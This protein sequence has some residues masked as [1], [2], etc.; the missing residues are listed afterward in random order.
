MSS[1]NVSAVTPS[2]VAISHKVRFLGPGGE[3]LWLLA[4]SVAGT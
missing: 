4:T 2:A 1:A 3:V